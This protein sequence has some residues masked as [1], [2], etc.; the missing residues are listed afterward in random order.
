[1]SLE[2]DGK[3][4]WLHQQICVSSVWNSEGIKLANLRLRSTEKK[5][6]KSLWKGECV[7]ECAGGR[8]EMGVES[9]NMTKDDE[10]KFK[11]TFQG[12]VPHGPTFRLKLAS[13][14]APAYKHILHHH[15]KEV[16]DNSTRHDVYLVKTKQ[17]QTNNNCVITLLG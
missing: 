15:M 12:L 16:K 4:E 13:F 7:T 2:W 10:G 8:G 3:N 14:E 5:K 17:K 11:K 6:E 1:M 9:E